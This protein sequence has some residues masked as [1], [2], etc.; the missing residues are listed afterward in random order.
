MIVFFSISAFLNLHDIFGGPV[1]VPMQSECKP[2]AY[3]MQ[4]SDE[5]QDFLLV[6][7]L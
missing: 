1:K 6:F 5:E 7:F 2:N 4:K 3:R